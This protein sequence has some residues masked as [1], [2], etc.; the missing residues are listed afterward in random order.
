[1]YNLRRH[2]LYYS[3]A[4]DITGGLIGTQLLFGNFLTHGIQIIHILYYVHKLN[5]IDRKK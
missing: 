5:Y 1:M 2:R 4:A 3:L